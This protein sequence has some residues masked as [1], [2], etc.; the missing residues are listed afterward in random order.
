MLSSTNLPH[1]KYLFSLTLRN[2]NGWIPLSTLA[3]Y[4]KIR[5]YAEA[6]GTHFIGDAIRDASDAGSGFLGKGRESEIVV[7]GRNE[8]V[9]RRE[10]LEKV[11]TAWDRTVYAASVVDDSYRIG[12]STDSLPVV[13]LR[14]ARRNQHHHPRRH[15]RVVRAIRAHH[16]RP[17]QAGARCIRDQGSRG[18][19]REWRAQIIEGDT[20]SRCSYAVRGVGG[21]VLRVCYG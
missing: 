7:D 17:I 4:P 20:V 10:V 9:R 2:P 5:A 14:L 8:R 3:K 21:G 1:D 13:R 19:Y 16:R 18:V 11:E 6:Y 12:P 15:R